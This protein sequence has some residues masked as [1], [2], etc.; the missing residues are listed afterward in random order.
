[1]AADVDLSGVLY[2][3]GVMRAGLGWVGRHTSML[4][5]FTRVWLSDDPL[6]TLGVAF[7]ANEKPVKAVV[8][9]SASSVSKERT[10][11]LLARSTLEK[12]ARKESMAD[13]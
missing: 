2:G 9:G 6:S 4:D 8:L 13:W 1:M 12:K 7:A 3:Q 11:A 5:S 10:D